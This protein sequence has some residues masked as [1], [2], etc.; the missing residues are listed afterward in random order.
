METCLKIGLAGFFHANARGDE[1]AFNRAAEELTLWAKQNDAVILVQNRK[2]YTVEDAEA[3]VRE[4]NA[5]EL[6][7]TLLLSAS[8][9]NGDAIK[10]FARLNSRIGLW[11]LPEA[12]QSGFLPMNSFCG[13][14]VMAGML[15]T[16]FQDQHI[17]FKWFYDFPSSAF[18][19]ERFRVTA[20]ALRAIKTLRQ[21]RIGCIG[22][23]VTG[24]DHLAV[25]ESLVKVKFGTTISRV[26]SVEEIVALADKIPGSRVQAEVAQIL[27]EGPASSRVSQQ[28]LERFARLN[29][30]LSDFAA[31]QDYSALAISC[32]S[33]LQQLF[34]VVACGSVSRLNQAGLVA[35]CEADIDGAIGML[36][37][38]AMSGSPASLVD[39]VS[40]DQLDQSLNIW[41]CGPAPRCLADAKGVV[42]DEHFDI[43]VRQQGEWCG[44]GAVASLQFKPGRVTLSRI[45]SKTQQLF[46][47]SAAVLDKPGYQGSSGWVHDFVMQGQAPT[48]KDV[49]SMIYNYRLDHHM[50]VGYGDQEAAYLE[51]ANWMDLTVCQPTPYVTYLESDK[52]QIMR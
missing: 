4:L 27:T 50:T 6:D 21:S 39:L 9:A 24:F 49:M 11:G 14:M 48:L 25:D 1:A 2:I 23:L 37:E 12:E 10:P 42:W 13:T 46:A 47:L 52:R 51:F 15:G 16:Y 7:F 20:A 31:A 34:D 41:H 30:A 35:S 38:R 19:Q 3:V 40:L 33:R 45:S 5:H 22:P 29:L 36:V 28:A 17:R 44:T 18:F 26:H 8:V 43:G 32:W